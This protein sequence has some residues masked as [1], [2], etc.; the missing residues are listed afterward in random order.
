MSRVLNSFEFYKAI[1]DNKT[2]TTEELADAATSIMKCCGSIPKKFGTRVNPDSDVY[3]DVLFRLES[4]W[5]KS[6]FSTFL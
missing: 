4:G 5:M 6:I 2:S 3:M 1:V